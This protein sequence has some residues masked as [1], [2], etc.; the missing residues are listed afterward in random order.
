VSKFAAIEARAT[1]YPASTNDVVW[2]VSL[3]RQ[4]RNSL[5]AIRAN[6]CGD[7]AERCAACMAIEALEEFND[8]ANKKGWTYCAACH[9]SHPPYTPP[10]SD[11]M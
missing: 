4:L 5:E 7:A 8:A 6:G 3:V 2:L 9:E 11:G 10:D 1:Q